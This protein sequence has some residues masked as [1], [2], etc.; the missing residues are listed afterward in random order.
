MGLPV[1][2]Q[3]TVFNGRANTPQP[4]TLFQKPKEGTRAQTFLIHW[5]DYPNTLDTNG[6]LQKCVSFD[7]GGNSVNSLSQIGAFY[8]D[9]TFCSAQVAIFIPDTQTW[10]QIA[11]SANGFIP[12]ITGQTKFVVQT[13][14]PPVATDFT[15][16]T[17]INEFIPPDQVGSQEVIIAGQPIKVDLNKQSLDPIDVNLAFVTQPHGDPVFVSFNAITPFTQF[18]APNSPPATVTL[19]NAVGTILRGFEVGISG[20]VAT[21]SGCALAFWLAL[22]GTI[23][24]QQF[25]DLQASQAIVYQLLSTTTNLALSGTQLILN[26][27]IA[28]GSLTFAGVAVANVFTGG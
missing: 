8:V 15:N 16:I 7:V 24:W 10:Y 23:I 18:V 28:G 19:Y 1:P 2:A 21:A 22:D 17:A 26:A 9:N 3:P 13:L 6:V 12:V 20:Q 11:A 5:A 27:K 25:V 4:I 14:I